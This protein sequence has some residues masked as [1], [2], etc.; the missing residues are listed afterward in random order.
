MPQ[1]LKHFVLNSLCSQTTAQSAG[2][3]QPAA[4]P[5]AA[6]AAVASVNGVDPERAKQLTQAVTEQVS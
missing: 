6:A 4:L 5:A 1:I 3:T 2:S